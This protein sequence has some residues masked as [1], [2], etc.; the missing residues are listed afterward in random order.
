MNKNDPPNDYNGVEWII[1][2]WEYF[3]KVLFVCWETNYHN[4]D[5]NDNDHYNDNDNDDK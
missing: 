1:Y 2:K 5:I 3:L 4:Y